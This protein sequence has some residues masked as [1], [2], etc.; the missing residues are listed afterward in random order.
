MRREA[1]L[2]VLLASL[3]Y[4]VTSAGAQDIGALGIR[5]PAAL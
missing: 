1:W 3:L 2:A 5:E 4:G